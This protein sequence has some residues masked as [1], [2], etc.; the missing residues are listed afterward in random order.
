MRLTQNGLLLLGA[1]T[2]DATVRLQR[3]KR[4]DDTPV[5][6]TLPLWYGRNIAKIRRV[7]VWFDDDAIR[8]S[9]FPSAGVI[10]ARRLVAYH[11]LRSGR[12][13]DIPQTSVVLLFR[14]DIS[15]IPSS[16]GL[17]GVKYA[18][19]PYHLPP[20]QCMNCQRF[21]HVVRMCKT[22]TR[23]KV[24]SG[25]HT[26]RHCNRRKNPRCANCGG[27]H[28]A[29]FAMCP[30][31]RRLY[32]PLSKPHQPPKP[33]VFSGGDAGGP[34]RRPSTTG[35]APRPSAPRT[36]GRPQP[37]PMRRTPQ[38]ILPRG[39]PQYPVQRSRPE[40]GVGA[41]KPLWSSPPSRGSY[42]A[43]A[44]IP[45]ALLLNRQTTKHPPP[46]ITRRTPQPSTFRLPA[47]SIQRADPPEG[48][49]LQRSGDLTCVAKY[50]DSGPDCADVDLQVFA[51]THRYYHSSITTTFPSCISWDFKGAIALRSGN[52]FVRYYFAS[53]HG[54]K[55]S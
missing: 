17:C 38:G 32:P 25:R 54:P 33:P 6:V 13:H 53:I 10:S 44:M 20:T 4:L 7:P 8:E 12:R 5:E 19:E 18:V 43:R 26:Y 48:V 2:A 11:A 23:C 21:G 14:P 1:R 34:P 42:G 15:Q 45:R 50:K 52:L 40:V 3:L 49:F 30:Q 24:C 41:R 16:V 51:R 36:P 27:P 28:A 47:F 9:L 55:Y 22:P 35:M 29:T 37:P 46:F 31:R 39:G